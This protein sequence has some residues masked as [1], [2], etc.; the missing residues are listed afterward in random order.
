M[1]VFNNVFDDSN[2]E[3]WKSLEKV[4]GTVI[5]TIVKR[6]S[7]LLPE[8]TRQVGYTN[9]SEKLLNT[10]ERFAMVVAS[11]ANVSNGE[12]Q[13]RQRRS[14]PNIGEGKFTCV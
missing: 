6:Q 8:Y 4:S 14:R 3:G 13:Y 12:Q 7:N 10:T 5:L 1:D 9:G 11:V 2:M